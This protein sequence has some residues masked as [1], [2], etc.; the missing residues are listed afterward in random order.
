MIKISD[1]TKKYGENIIL[2]NTTHNFPNSGISCV[3]GVSG[4]GK[5]TLLNILAGF[6]TDFEGE[7]IVK[8]RNI[9]KYTTDELCEYRK[10]EIGFIFQNY[11]LV[12]GYTVLE[13]ILLASELK[14]ASR[15]ENIEKAKKLLKTIGILEKIDEKVENLSG[16]QKQRVAI[17]RALIKEPQI[18]LADEPTGAL[19]RKTTN[20]IMGILKEISKDR[21]VIVITHDH[22]ICSF[23]DEVLNIEEGKISVTKESMHYT[24]T[25]NN[26]SRN[27][28]TIEGRKPNICK[29]STKNFRLHIVRYFFVALS[30]AIGISAF[31]MSLSFN[32]VIKGA[33]NDFQQKNIVLNNG[34][35]RL[36]EGSDLLNELLE[37]DRI[38]N[39]YYQY[40]TVGISLKFG[41]E[42]MIF[43]KYIP[44]AKAQVS[45]TFGRMSKKGEMEIA[46][47]LGLAQ[48]LSDDVES[49]LGKELSINYNGSTYPVTISGIYDEEYDHFFVSPEVEQ[50]IYSI[51]NNNRPRSINYDVKDFNDVVEVTNE[52]IEKGFTPE[53][54][55]NQVKTLTKTF[56]SMRDLFLVISIIILSIAL[57]ISIL[58][59]G[60]LSYARY[61][62]IGLLSALGFTQGQISGLLVLENLMLTILSSVLG[63]FGVLGTGTVFELALGSSVD[64]STMQIMTSVLIT[65]VT[66]VTIGY[67]FTRKLT[68]TDPAVALRK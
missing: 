31:V 61:S 53:T 55:V 3:L 12:K 47:S 63:V 52:L 15:E 59:M 29:Y 22:K 49:L 37:D 42:E 58:L 60:K 35:I 40:Y 66:V 17:A 9:G 38:E 16:G 14:G 10:N 21:L 68:S 7:V 50:S 6:D 34:Y 28:S 20:E 8:G 30:L 39:A 33:I 36:E 48:K 13:N 64:I 44:Q 57:F 19:D 32:Q 62:E 4:V 46:I 11:N 25:S 56:D 5:T 1:L 23:A 18:I 27:N 51:S 41:N 65:F 43:D 45:F 24:T 67:F 54:A 2:N 26:S